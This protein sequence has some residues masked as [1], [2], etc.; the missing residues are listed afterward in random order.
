MEDFDFTIKAGS[1]KYSNLDKEY[2]KF[3][4]KTLINLNDEKLY[5]WETYNLI[6][7]GLLNDGKHETFQEVKYRLTDGEN[8][9]D[10]MLD[11]ISRENNYNGLLWLMK[12]RIEEYLDED[13][14]EQFY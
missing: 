13:F 10:I 8:P 11:I 14:F 9:N 7:E 1:G 5:R 3:L 6:M 4:K 12:K 2:E